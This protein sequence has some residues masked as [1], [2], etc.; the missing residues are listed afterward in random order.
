M[1]KILES[2]VNILFL[3]DESEISFSLVLAIYIVSY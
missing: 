3:I 1:E 2:C